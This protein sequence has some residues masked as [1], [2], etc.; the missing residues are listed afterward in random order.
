MK[1]FLLI[2]TL[3]LIL[4]SHFLTLI[5]T[6]DN[7]KDNSPKINFDMIFMHP[8]EQTGITMKKPKGF[9]LRGE[10]LPLFP[11]TRFI[12]KSW[13]STYTFKKPGVY[14]FYVQP[15]PYFE[16]NEE[17]FISHVPK[18]IVSA[19]GREDGWDEPIGL[20][21]EIIPL[22]KP[23]GIYKGNL[24]QAKVLNHGKPASNIK[25][26]VEL[27]NTFGLKAPTASHI[28][29]VIKTDDNGIFSF[30]MSHE[31]WWGFAALIEEGQKELNGKLYPV[32]NGAL[33]WI[34]AY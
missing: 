24:F 16:A 29:Q 15:E 18:I 14:S 9:F 10:K 25:V 21:Y 12:H 26:E 34:K 32:E 4:N 8:F 7:I 6:T 30:V 20:E 27:Y 2:I 1:S 17:K 28:T 23:F 3:S 22:V 33:F 31:G 19:F 13:T 11:Q 5:P